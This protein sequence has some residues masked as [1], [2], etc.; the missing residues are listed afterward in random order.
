MSS[1][2]EMCNTGTRGCPTAGSAVALL[3]VMS[4]ST[5]T[6]P[7]P[8][9]TKPVMI[10]ARLVAP[11]GT[12]MMCN[13]ARVGCWAKASDGFAVPATPAQSSSNRAGARNSG[14][15]AWSNAV[16]PEAT[17]T[18]AKAA[19]KRAAAPPVPLSAAMSATGK[20][21]RDTDGDT[22]EPGQSPAASANHSRAFATTFVMPPS[23][24]TDAHP[25]CDESTPRF[26]K[27]SSIH[28][29]CIFSQPCSNINA[30]DTLEWRRWPKMTRAKTASPSSA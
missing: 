1:L 14:D 29:L 17:A 4:A 28:A 9:P 3:A 5:M 6:M 11:G 25:N 12:S 27:P 2:T 16:P 20:V 19:A 24:C 15:P 21:V 22:A 18:R 13:P 7:A 10:S 30:R 23:S 8:A 26:S